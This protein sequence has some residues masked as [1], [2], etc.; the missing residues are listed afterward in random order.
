MDPKAVTTHLPCFANDI[1]LT[2]VI[3]TGASLTVYSFETWEHLGSPNLEAC[4]DNFLGFNGSI[5]RCMGTFVCKI[6]T[7]HN[8][9]LIQARV[10]PPK[11]LYTP[12]LLGLDWCHISKCLLSPSKNMVSFQTENGVKFEKLVT[13]TLELGLSNLSVLRS[14]NSHT[15]KEPAQ[16]PTTQVRK[17]ANIDTKTSAPRQWVNIHAIFAEGPRVENV[18]FGESERNSQTPR[19]G[20]KVPLTFGFR[21]EAGSPIATISQLHGTPSNHAHRTNSPPRLRP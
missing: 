12:C 21:N 1:P 4:N 14:M 15:Q 19:V 2:T 5:S 10:L 11:V 3:D 20:T 8:D 9:H 16:P 17:N 13:T 18:L 6:K 7:Q